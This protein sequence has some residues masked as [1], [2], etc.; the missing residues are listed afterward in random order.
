MAHSN[1]YLNLTVTIKKPTPLCVLFYK[2]E[3]LSILQ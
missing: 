2:D 1:Q 3:M